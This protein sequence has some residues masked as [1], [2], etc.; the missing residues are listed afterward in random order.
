MSDFSHLILGL[1]LTASKLGTVTLRGIGPDLL[2][3]GKLA[4]ES[5]P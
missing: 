3:Q 5:I 4:L 2:K 1:T